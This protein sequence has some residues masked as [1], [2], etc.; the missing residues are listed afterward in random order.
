MQISS[1]KDLK[2]WQKAHNLVLSVYK[3]TKPFP[4]EE[5]YGLTSQLRR[6]VTSIAANIAEGKKRKSVAD[7]LHFLNMA[8]TS[9]EEV[10]YYIIL[11]HDLGYTEKK[12]RDDLECK[13]HEVGLMLNG[14]MEALRKHKR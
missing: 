11:S 6:A 14:L 5:I 3:E 9:L 7:Y 12:V 10:K 4:K 8:E 1:F 13:A 2:V